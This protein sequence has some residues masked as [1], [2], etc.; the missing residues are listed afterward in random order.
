MERE[1]EAEGGR[2]KREFSMWSNG[3]DGWLAEA[4]RR[5]DEKHLS[6]AFVARAFLRG[7]GR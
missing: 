5:R 2:M 1:V 7:D 4:R 6:E 3:G